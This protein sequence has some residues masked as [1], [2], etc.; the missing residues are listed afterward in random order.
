MTLAAYNTVEILI[1]YLHH[2]SLVW[3]AFKYSALLLSIE[4]VWNCLRKSVF[5]S[6]LQYVVFRVD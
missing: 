1:L 4:V 3:E 5:R 2:H 6:L